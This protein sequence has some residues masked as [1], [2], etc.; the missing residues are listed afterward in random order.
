ML[1]EVGPIRAIS[2]ALNVKDDILSKLVHAAEGSSSG[3][4]TAGGGHRR[5]LQHGSTTSS[6]AFP[7]S[8]T[9][10]ILERLTSKKFFAY[11]G[12]ETTPPCAET[13][14][15]IVL[16]SPLLV[17]AATLAGVAADRF[18]QFTLGERSQILLSDNSVVN[19]TGNNNRP[20]QGLNGRAIATTL[21]G[22]TVAHEGPAAS[23][24]SSGKD[25]KMTTGAILMLTVPM[26][27]LVLVGLWLC[28]KKRRDIKED[29][30]KAEEEWQEEK[31]EMAEKNK[32]RKEAADRRFEP[33]ERV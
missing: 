25:E 13:A 23:S 16:R 20:V 32:E 17:D 19:V 28:W 15:W 6:S 29:L 21:V 7:I 11:N 8:I 30:K 4:T 12:S 14:Q 24:G 3:S 2:T 10:D 31:L 5:K 27:L 33:F 9:S 1:L 22:G 26:G 18:H